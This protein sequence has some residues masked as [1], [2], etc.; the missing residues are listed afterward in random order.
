MPDVP[1]L[2]EGRRVR[3]SWGSKQEEV[4]AARTPALPPRPELTSGR[5]RVFVRH[6][7]CPGRTKASAYTG[8][9]SNSAAALKKDAQMN[10]SRGFWWLAD[11]TT[12]LAIVAGVGMGIVSLL[13]IATGLAR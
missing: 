2:A 1:P 4:A 12:D 5:A 6:C 7:D 8:A 9:P 11:R 13:A 10:F 3:N